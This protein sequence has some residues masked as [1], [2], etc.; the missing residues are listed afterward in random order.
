MRTKA[1]EADSLN[2]ILRM[3]TPTNRLVALVALATGLRIS[4]VL[5]IR[6]EQLKKDRFTVF[7]SK[8]GKK[9]TVRLNKTLRLRVVAQ[10]GK[11]YA[12]E[13]R[14]DCF[15]HRSRTTIWKDMN[16]VSR[17]CR[18]K[19]LAPHSLRKTYAKT[20]RAEGLTEAEVQKALNH[21]SETVTRLYTMADELGL[22]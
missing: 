16:R 3:L 12:F 20:L 10:A 4:D 1:I 22:K 15:K 7:E 13:G 19:G 17:L 9:K 6:T 21:S 5:S 2:A 18:L 14:C 11:I 8:T